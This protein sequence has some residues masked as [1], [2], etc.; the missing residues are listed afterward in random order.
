MAEPLADLTPGLAADLLSRLPPGTARDR[1][2]AYL[3]EPRGMWRGRAGLVLAPADTDE[4]AR[5]VGFAARHRIGIVP[6]GGGTG[7][8]GGQVLAEGA[9]PILLSLERMNAIRAVHADENVLIAGAGAILADVQAAAAQADRLFPLS[10]ASEGS[11]RIG[12]LLSTNAGGVNV[13]RYGNARDLC[14]GVEAVLPDGSVMYGL[15]RLRKDNTGYDIRNLL[16]GAEGTLGIVTAASLRLFPRPAVRG[17]AILTVRDPA[18]ALTLLGMAQAGGGVSA[19][20]LISG[21]GLRFLAEAGLAVRQPF[22]DPPD[23]CVLVD[24]GL[25]AGDDAMTRLEALFAAGAEAGL[26]DDGVIASSEAQRAELWAVRERIPEANRHVGA[27]ASNDIS[28]PLSEIAPFMDRAGTA[29]TAIAPVRINAFGHLGDGNLHYN[30]F[31]PKGRAKAEFA[32]LADDLRRVV[33]D[34]VHDH[35]GS[36]SA[37]HGVGRLKVAQLERY[38]DPARLAAMRAI[39]AALDPRGIMNPGA[40]LRRV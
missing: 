13:L 31:P 24:L 2:P 26:A 11:A 28:L 30:L 10:L 12:G 27:I 25:P 34:L 21:Q 7:L 3:T 1:G 29:L 38:G 35:G 19:F 17:T 15:R 37:E 6:W 5:I 16:I 9:L 33:D 40:V 18:A 14:L 8:V 20:E 32:D 23:W 22:A 4:V 39:K 36:F